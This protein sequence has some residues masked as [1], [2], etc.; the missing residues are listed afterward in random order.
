M[1]NGSKPNMIVTHPLTSSI[2]EKSQ[3]LTRGHVMA[4]TDL[5][6]TTGVVYLFEKEKKM[7]VGDGLF[8]MNAYKEKIQMVKY[9]NP[10]ILDSVRNKD[11][12]KIEIR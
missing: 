10:N 9:I 3:F 6:V 7:T 5:Y 12:L 11:C 1:G 4:F 2:V 8:I